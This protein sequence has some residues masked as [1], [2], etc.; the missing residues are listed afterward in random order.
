[1]RRLLRKWLLGDEIV[2]GIYA[3]DVELGDLKARVN[4]LERS[5]GK[6]EREIND[7]ELALEEVVEDYVK[8]LRP[9]RASGKRGKR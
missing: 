2:I 1:M 3:R 8:R 5:W 4:D 9:K 7:I 6:I